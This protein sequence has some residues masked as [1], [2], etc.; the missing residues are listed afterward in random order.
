M[1][2]VKNQAVTVLGIVLLATGLYFLKTADDPK[3]FLLALP[4]VCIGIG[5]GALGY[6]IGE[7]ITGRTLRKN[8]ALRKQDEINKNDERNIMLSNRTKAKA[9][10]LMIF[11]FRALMLAFA[12]MGVDMIPLLLLVAAYLCVEGY[13]VYCRCKYEKEM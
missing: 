8:P 1:R 7:I 3:G 4:Y 2:E 13:A 9:Y 11:V 6:G 12:L 5:C 10:D